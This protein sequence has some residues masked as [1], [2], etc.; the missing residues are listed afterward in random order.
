MG[1]GVLSIRNSTIVGNQ[2]TPGP[3]G[4]AGSGGTA[5]GNTGPTGNSNGGGVYDAGTLNSSSSIFANNTAK[6][7][8]DVS[9]S[10]ET[11]SNNLLKAPSGATGIAN[12]TSGNIVGVDPKLATF[13]FA[14]FVLL[15]LPGSPVI[16]R[17][18]NSINLPTDQRGLPRVGGIR[19]DMGAVELQPA[20][21]N[22][23]GTSTYHA[24]GSAM[25]LAGGATV[26]DADSPD[27]GGGKLTVAIAA[28]A[29]ANDRLGIVNQGTAAGQIGVSGSNVTYGGVVIGTFSGGSGS[30][31][32]VVQFNTNATPAAAQA[33]VRV[34][35]FRSVSATPPTAQRKITF[36]INDGD[37]TNS[38][39]ATATKLVNV[40]AT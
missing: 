20:K 2:A 24:G 17:G 19:A 28:N 32:L 15:P 40:S 21:V 11:A 29:N 22:L 26:S 38:S 16:D 18:D 8:P 13:D 4:A 34:I 31:P 36:V 33:L 1:S 35:T 27:F 3:G 25:V 7:D 5:A 30:T 9:G 14:K 10:F 12:N 23:G 39:A 37:G 6:A